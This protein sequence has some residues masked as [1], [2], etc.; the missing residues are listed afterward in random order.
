MRQE[1][2]V[3]PGEGDC[4]CSEH[5]SSQHALVKNSQVG[6]SVLWVFRGTGSTCQRCLLTEGDLNG[7][8]A[9]RGVCRA[10]GETC[11]WLTLST[12]VGSS[13]SVLRFCP[14]PQTDRGRGLLASYRPSGA[15]TWTAGEGGERLLGCW[16]A[17]GLG[18]L[19]DLL[20]PGVL[21]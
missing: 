10:A 7:C 3:T 18:F 14:S 6:R 15:R 21:E 8:E 1:V 11:S 17:V 5:P 2:P 13:N 4:W 12:C 20:W 16:N 19:P 9:H